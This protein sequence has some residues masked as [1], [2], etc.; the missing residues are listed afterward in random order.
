[1]FHRNGPNCWLR[2]VQFEFR[3]VDTCPSRIATS[4]RRRLYAPCYW[5]P[6]G[7]L[8]FTKGNDLYIAE[9]DGHTPEVCHRAGHSSDISFS[10]DG[11]AS[12]SRFQAWLTIPRNLG[13]P[14]QWQRDASVIPAEQPTR[15]VLWERTPTASIMFFKAHGKALA[16]FDCARPVIGEESPREPVQ[17]T[18]DHCSLP[19]HF[20]AKTVRSCSWSAPNRGQNW[21]ATIRNPEISFP[22]SVASP[23]AMSTSRVMANG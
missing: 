20:P 3:L 19:N 16:T 15:R 21:C 8:V 18:T 7:K 10:P 5:A 23:P 2:G 14:C 22:I 1:M 6:N 11:T 12:G 4:A 13:S 9:H 17:L